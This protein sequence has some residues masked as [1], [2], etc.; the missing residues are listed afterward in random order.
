MTR[1]PL[2]KHVLI[3]E[4]AA[5]NKLATPDTVSYLNL[6]VEIDDG[7]GR[8]RTYQLIW[9]SRFPNAKQGASREPVRKALLEMLPEIFE[10]L[11]EK[12]M[13]VA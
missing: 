6:D 4:L 2:E 5:M 10:A 3:N 9:D 12:L 13:E 7:S 11:R 1:E 8:P